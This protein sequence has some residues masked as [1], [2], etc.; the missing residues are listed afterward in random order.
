MRETDSEIDRDSYT[1]ARGGKSE[2]EKEKEGE[3]AIH[4]EMEISADRNIKEQEQI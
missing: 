4:E 1:Q 2:N 3:V